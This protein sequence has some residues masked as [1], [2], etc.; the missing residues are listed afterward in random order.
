M[1]G[2]YS[3]PE[4]G[5]LFFGERH[6]TGWYFPTGL[7]APH[8]QIHLFTNQQVI[9]ALLMYPLVKK[10]FN[11]QIKLW[12]LRTVKCVKQYQGHHNEYAILPL[13][14]NEE[15]GLLTAGGLTSSLL[16]VSAVIFLCLKAISQLQLLQTGQL[17]IL[18]NSAELLLQMYCNQLLKLKCYGC[19]P[20]VIAPAY[21]SSAL[22]TMFR[23]SHYPFHSVAQKQ[24]RK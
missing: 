6:R 18:Q 8:Y 22:S 14:V 20:T 3:R 23:K 4:G 1:T 10:Y 21:L 19:T 13:H 9:S 5:W 12:D 17:L 2:A 24:S 15:E 7:S 16:L 11:F